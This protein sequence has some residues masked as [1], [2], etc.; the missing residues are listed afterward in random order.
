MTPTEFR[1]A[2]HML[3]LSARQLGAI[4]DTDERTV[5]RWEADP[6]TTGT[7]RPPNPTAARVMRWMLDGWRPPEW[8][9]RTRSRTPPR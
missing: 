7:A 3:G 9:T 1:E 6:E 4:L 2:R 8:P 5:R